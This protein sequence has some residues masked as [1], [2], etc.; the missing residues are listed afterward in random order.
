MG[1]EPTER[2]LRAGHAFEVLE[3]EK[4]ELI[5]YEMAYIFSFY[6]ICECIFCIWIE[7]NRHLIRPEE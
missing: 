3:T 6:F 2:S 5:F 4:L 7:L 1:G